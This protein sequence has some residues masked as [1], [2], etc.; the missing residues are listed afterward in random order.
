MARNEVNSDQ[1]VAAAGH[2]GRAEREPGPI[3]RR[4]GVTG[5]R[6]SLAM[7][8][9]ENRAALDDAR[10]N[11]SRLGGRCAALAGMTASMPDQAEGKA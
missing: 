2:P 9:D 1:S 10:I 11:G 8:R 5:S 4:G 7:R 6:G 3:E